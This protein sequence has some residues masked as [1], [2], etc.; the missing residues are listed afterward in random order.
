MAINFSVIKS[1]TNTE[2]DF[3]TSQSYTETAY[4]YWNLNNR[5]DSI[6]FGKNLNEVLTSLRNGDYFYQ[7][8]SLS[9]MLT[10]EVLPFLTSWASDPRSIRLKNPISISPEGVNEMTVQELERYETKTRAKLSETKLGDYYLQMLVTGYALIS[11]GLNDDGFV[12]QSEDVYIDY[13]NEEFMF[14]DRKIP[15]DFVTFLAEK[16]IRTD[17]DEADAPDYQWVTNANEIDLEAIVKPVETDRESVKDVTGVKHGQYKL[18]EESYIEFVVINS[19]VFARYLPYP[20]M[21]WQPFVKS[22]KDGH[23]MGVFELC[24]GEE[25]E[26]MR[27]KQVIRNRIHEVA[28]ASLF[29]D[30]ANIQGKADVFQN[31]FNDKII[32][33]DLNN[34]NAIQFAP[35]RA[36][37]IEYFNQELQRMEE[38][39]RNK[40][41]LHKVP[42]NIAGSNTT[43][44]EASQVFKSS[45]RKMRALIESFMPIYARM[46]QHV[47]LR[48]DGIDVTPRYIRN[49]IDLQLSAQGA[50]LILPHMINII[51][52]DPTGKTF[53]GAINERTVAGVFYKIYDFYNLDVDD[54]A[55]PRETA[56]SNAQ[57]AEAAQ[58]QE[59]DAAQK[60]G[61]AELKKAEA[62]LLGAQAQI[63]DKEVAA[64][65]LELRKGIHNDKI[66]FDQSKLEF[67]IMQHEDNMEIKNIELS[68]KER[69][70]E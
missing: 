9:S 33:V 54:L 13:K 32:D 49:P 70:D 28:N 6:I 30:G 53:G 20:V 11:V 14:I 47:L 31:F 48:D 40:T 51:K 36:A 22:P 25:L 35:S 59:K 55:T 4:E 60:I 7:E 26:T 1:I 44:L 57:A 62:Q 24:S 29:V 27:V 50:E 68:I 56:L 43:A 10:L 39:A 19:V 37:E 34:G 63:M 16:S 18:D 21:C 42:V 23:P 8:S 38:A 45:T 15:N 12:P 2:A 52:E 41:G 58:Q 3:N 67:Q 5:E 61:D 66:A 17:E 65:E 46:I 64:T 69:K